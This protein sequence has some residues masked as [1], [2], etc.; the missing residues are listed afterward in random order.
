MK[1]KIFSALSLLVVSLIF[2]GY[3]EDAAAHT[4]IRC[5]S[6]DSLREIKVQNLYSM[7][8]PQFMAEDTLLNDEASLEYANLDSELY[9]IV[10]HES[11][12]EYVRT[13]REMGE[14]ETSKSP[15]E[16]YANTQQAFC[17]NMLGTISELTPLVKGTYNGL[18]TYSFDMRGSPAGI[19]LKVLYK[20][21][22]VQG[23]E[24]LYL[25][26]TYTLAFQTDVYEKRMTAMLDSFMEF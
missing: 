3:N 5:A 2:S 8:V 14:Y 20:I 10:I 18:E 21:R 9:V 6:G 4:K 16:N 12:A 7:M 22:V 17:L 19:D 13:Y 26:L 15:L 11:L 25:L 1:V 23:K 24:H